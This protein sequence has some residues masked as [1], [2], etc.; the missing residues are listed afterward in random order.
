MSQSAIRVA[1]VAVSTLLI[2]GY[3]STESAAQTRDEAREAMLARAEAAELDT[4][5]VPAPRR[6]ALTPHVGFR[7]DAVLGGVRHRTRC[8]LCG[9]ERRLSSARRTNS[10]YT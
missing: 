3:G 7:E 8:R 2:V 9:R 5:Y 1:G 10:G 4:E 6:P